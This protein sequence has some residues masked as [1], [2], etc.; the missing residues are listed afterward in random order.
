M[1]PSTLDTPLDTRR[2]IGTGWGIDEVVFPANRGK[3]LRLA[4]LGLMA[5]L[6]L[7]H[8]TVGA[9]RAWFHGGDTPGVRAFLTLAVMAILAGYVF[10]WLLAALFARPR[11]TANT[12]VIVLQ[13]LF[14]QRDLAWTSL[15]PFELRSF[16]LPTGRQVF[17]ASA[18]I[19][20]PD[21]TGFRF[22]R[23]TIRLGDGFTRPL[24]ALVDALNSRRARLLV[25]AGFHAQAAE[26]PAAEIIGLADFN[27]PILSYVILVF[28]LAIFFLEQKFAVDTSSIFRPS[29]ATLMAMGALAPLRIVYDGEWYRL[30]TAP[31]LHVSTDHLIG[32][33][34]ALLW[35]GRVLERL[36][37]RLW[38]LAILLVGGL[39]GSL[40]SLALQSPNV[41]SV[42]ASGALMAA[43]AAILVIGFREP[44]SS[45]LRH[46]LHVLALWM[47]IP[48]IL[49]YFLGRAGEHIAYASHLG[50]ALVGTAMGLILLD[51]WPRGEH[52]PRRTDIAAAVCVV[53]LS[54]VIV[55]VVLAAIHY[56]TYDVTLIPVEGPGT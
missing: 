49:P 42:G 46:S 10:A 4:I 23:K 35:G 7:Q 53:G 33:C 26:Q 40:A 27:G 36:V 15:S 20:E 16:V 25:A 11:L 34:V 31:L 8:P 54:L 6:Y 51:I 56:Q 44:R 52:I 3:L 55:S 50:G 32:N 1:A 41:I 43:F 24:P 12:E 21:A 39:G 2:P 28:L 29:Y 48:A 13:T 14:G 37:G 22:G 47:M 30:W 17:R 5:E 45:A 19:L 18:R 38:Y 9:F